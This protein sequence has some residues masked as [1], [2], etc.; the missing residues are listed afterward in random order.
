[1][2][3]IKRY[4][5]KFVPVLCVLAVLVSCLVFPAS[6]TEIETDNVTGLLY[7]DLLN[8]SNY[9]FYPGAL[10]SNKPFFEFEGSENA[11]TV[12]VFWDPVNADHSFDKLVFS[13]T[14]NQKP[15]SVRVANEV[16]NTFTSA[17]FEGSMDGAADND[18]FFYSVSLG[19]DS[20]FLKIE[21]N[22]S[23]AYRGLFGIYGCVGLLDTA[24]SISS[25]DI[26]R[27]DCYDIT[28]G[29]KIENATPIQDRKLPYS[30]S[31]SGDYKSNFYIVIDG[32]DF[33]S[34]LIENAS[35]LLATCNST[36]WSSVSLIANGSDGS[37]VTD[38]QSNLF[39]VHEW[40]QSSDLYQGMGMAETYNTFQLDF[41][42]SGYDMTKYDL[43]ISIGVDAIDQVYDVNT[44]YIDFTIREVSY[45]P[46]VEHTPWY[47]SFFGPLLGGIDNAIW[48]VRNLLNDFK[49][50]VSDNFSWL[51][52]KLDEYFG[53]DG[54]LAQAGDQMSEQAG[55]M[56]EA[57][58]A[59]NS[60]DKPSLDTDSMFS[61]MLD[62]DT[63]GLT[64]LA[65][66]TSNAYVT[67]ILVVVF[68]FALCSYVFFGK[69]I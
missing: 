5:N 6:A 24:S 55:Q 31:A 45:V 62:F 30:Y 44:P 66:M 25:V 64:I 33:V 22:F 48:S 40:A 56:N 35:V 39:S 2:H 14:S 18:I 60:T 12:S 16:L 10:N 42:L 1:M 63:G 36:I 21:C 47:K 49:A 23:T 7:S 28:E 69:R 32:N 68:T 8:V 38:I 4:L 9:T 46:F 11:K 54:S 13:I 20:Y 50:E 37:D 53:D 61:G 65:S 57:N 58:D 15:S 34:P 27:Q 29:Y 26:Y 59:L 52:Y 67:Q 41:N 51:M 17:T 43:M 19:S 3:L